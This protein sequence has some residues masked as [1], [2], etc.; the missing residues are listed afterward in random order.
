MNM[1]NII[2][3]IALL[4]PVIAMGQSVDGALKTLTTAGTST[5]YTVSE[6]LP[7]AYDQKERFIIR[8]HTDCGANPTINRATLGAKSLKFAGNTA[9]GAGDL[10]AKGFYICSY[11]A[12][13]GYYQVHGAGSSG[14]SLTDGEGT[15]ANGTAVDLGGTFSSS[16]DLVSTSGTTGFNIQTGVLASTDWAAYAMTGLL[17][18]EISVANAATTNAAKIKLS[19]SHGFVIEDGSVDGEGAKYAADYAGLGA[20]SLIHQS[21]ADG[22]YALQTGSLNQ[23]SSDATSAELR[24]LLSDETGTGVAVFGTAPTLSNAIVGT[25]SAADNSTKAASTAYADAAVAAASQRFGFACSDLTT[26]LTTGTSKGYISLPAA[27]TV[28]GVYA[29]VLTAQG[30]GSIL[31]IDINEAG[32]TILSTKITIDNSETTTLTAATPAVISDS[33]IA[34]GALLTADFDQVGTGGAGVIVWVIGHF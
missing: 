3:F 26:A 33:S 24:G 34:A 1:K 22:R 28:T 9:I 2:L 10:K 32:S 21:Y 12:T 6:A 8:F 5:A 4:L 7:V 29:S 17:G 20:L 25:Q 15:T 19:Y 23:F 27:F 16:V 11:N 31:T 14:G 30:S 18:W 13:D